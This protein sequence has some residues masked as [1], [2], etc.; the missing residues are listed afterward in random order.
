MCVHAGAR[1]VC[2]S[3]YVCVCTHSERR[4]LKVCVCTHSERRVLEV[5]VCAHE[6]SESCVLVTGLK[7][8]TLV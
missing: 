7:L 3:V 4:V 1:D 8:K 5:C 2:I 6:Q